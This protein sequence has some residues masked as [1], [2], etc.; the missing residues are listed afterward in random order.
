MLLLRFAS[1]QP[2]HLESMKFSHPISRSL[3]LLAGGFCAGSMTS[4]AAVIATEYFNGYGTS[5]IQSNGS[6]LNG[7]S[8]WTS[9]WLNADEKYVPNLNIS[10]SIAG[11]DN[12]A[13]LSGSTNGAMAYSGNLPSVSSATRSFSTSSTTVWFS[14]LISID[15]IWDRAVLWIDATQT[16]AGDTGNDFIGVLDGAIQMRYNNTNVTSAGAPTVGTHLLLAKA[17]IDVSGTNDRLSF[18][19][20]PN[21]TGGEGGLGTATYTD[22]SADTFGTAING[23]GVLLVDRDFDGS[24]YTSDPNNEVVNGELIDAIRVGTTFADVIPEPSTALLGG[25]GMLAL[26][27][28]RRT[29]TPV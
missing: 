21:L 27:R 10:T 1:F 18:W 16:S 22:A 19:F 7:G 26:L 12:S 9:A 3:S 28:R 14:A 2:I 11:Y 24:F 17:E 8:G 15:E 13:N 23:I 5:E 4:N 25:L 29:T 6:S 20:N